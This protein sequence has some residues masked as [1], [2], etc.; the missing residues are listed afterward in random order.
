MNYWE[1]KNNTKTTIG[2]KDGSVDL[3]NGSIHFKT[4]GNNLTVVVKDNDDNILNEFS[5]SLEN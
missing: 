5:C 4:D 3:G 2:P 1:I